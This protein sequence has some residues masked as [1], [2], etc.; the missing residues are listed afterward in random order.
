[1]GQ[2]YRAQ[3]GKA[4]RVV[5]SHARHRLRQWLCRKHKVRARERNRFLDEYLYQK[6]GLVRLERLIINLPWANA[7]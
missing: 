4:Y 3:T 5:D 6:L 1:M 2:C 7:I